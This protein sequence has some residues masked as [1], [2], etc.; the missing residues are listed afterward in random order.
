MGT[1][2]EHEF[3]LRIAERTNERNLR[4]REQMR[5]RQSERLDRARSE[6]ERLAGAFRAADPRIDRV[7]LFGSVATGDI[8]NRDF[9]IDLAV[10]SAAYLRLVSIAL[11]SDFRVDVVDLGNVRPAIREAIEREGKVLYAKG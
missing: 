4:E 6:A 3:L 2:T 5:C 10:S 11:D 8:G 7:V 9:D 1:D